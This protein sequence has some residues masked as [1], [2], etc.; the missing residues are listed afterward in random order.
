M[1][2]KENSPTQHVVKIVPRRANVQ[3]PLDIGDQQWAVFYKE[4]IL[5]SVPVAL[6]RRYK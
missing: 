2:S 6:T 5:Y 3:R 4:M 1:Q